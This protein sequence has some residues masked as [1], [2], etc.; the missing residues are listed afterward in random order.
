MSGSMLC[1][2]AAGNCAISALVGLLTGSDKVMWPEVALTGSRFSAC[3][4]FSPRFFLISSNIATEGH[5]PL[6][7]FPWVCATGNYATPVVTEGHVIPWKLALTES[8][9]CACPA[10]PPRFFLSSSN[11]AT[12]GHLTPSGFPWVCACPTRAHS[13]N[14]LPDSARDWCHFRSRDW[15]DFRSSVMVRSTSRSTSNATLSVPIYY[16]HHIR[17]PVGS[18]Q[19]LYN[20]YLLLLR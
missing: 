14:I 11:M 8:M 5:W 20:W 4:A 15:R 9:F 19:T 10:F 16:L 18:N 1:A 17:A 2:C 12:E 7:E 3:P 13:Q 6:S